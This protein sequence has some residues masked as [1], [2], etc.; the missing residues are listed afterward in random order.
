MTVVGILRCKTKV[1]GFSDASGA[2]AIQKAN[3]RLCSKPSV[4]SEPW[5]ITFL[6]RICFT[7]IATGRLGHQ[8]VSCL[9]NCGGDKLNKTGLN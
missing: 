9:L 2:P 8:K 1:T 6:I 7:G 3:K 4:K 5:I